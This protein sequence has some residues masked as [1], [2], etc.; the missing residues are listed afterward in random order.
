MIIQT[1]PPV[2]RDPGPYAAK[3]SCEGC[4]CTLSRYNPSSSCAPCS[5]GDWKTGDEITNRQ[6][7]DVE[8][9]R[10]EFGMDAH[11]DAPFRTRVL[12]NVGAKP[13]A[14]I[15]VQRSFLARRTREDDG[16]RDHYRTRSLEVWFT[17]GAWD[18][19]NVDLVISWKPRLRLTVRPA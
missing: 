6:L 9:A 8:V 4:G 10:I 2:Q 11:T 12:F 19:R 16:L 15:F 7:K 1:K 17:A 14:L 18:R 3:R 13:V 5:G